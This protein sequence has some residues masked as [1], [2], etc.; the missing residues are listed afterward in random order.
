MNKIYQTTQSYSKFPPNN[1]IATTF[2]EY[3]IPDIWSPLKQVVF[4]CSNTEFLICISYFFIRALNP[5]SRREPPP[6]K[7]SYFFL[8]NLQIVLSVQNRT[9]FIRKHKIYSD[10]LAFYTIECSFKH[11]QL[12]PLIKLAVKRRETKNRLR[13]SEAIN[14]ASKFLPTWRNVYSLVPF[15][16]WPKLSFFC[17]PS[18]RIVIIND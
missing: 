11:G 12:W 8:E 3:T 15:I 4:W 7:K 5:S 10:M 1:P 14:S 18:H 2:M 17:F 6:S 9:M 16:A 13:D